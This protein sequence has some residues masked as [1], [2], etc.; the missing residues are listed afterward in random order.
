MNKTSK[1]LYAG[2]N[3]IVFSILSLHIIGSVISWYTLSG[4]ETDGMLDVL[5]ALTMTGVVSGV[6]VFVYAVVEYFCNW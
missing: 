3:L 5:V 6:V 1:K 4:Y 2:I